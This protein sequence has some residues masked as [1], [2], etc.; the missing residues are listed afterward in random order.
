MV[1]KRAYSNRRKKFLIH[2]IVYETTGKSL[3]N[4]KSFIWCDKTKNF[5]D[6]MCKRC[7]KIAKKLGILNKIKLGW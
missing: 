2:H 4:S 7:V 5:E 3:C 1:I 6:T